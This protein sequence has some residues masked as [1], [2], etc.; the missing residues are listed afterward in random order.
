[1]RTRCK[2]YA[3]YGLTDARVKEIMQYCRTST[4]SKII[5]QAAEKANPSLAVYL[6]ESLKDRM[7]YDKLYKK[8]FIPLGCADFYAYRRLTIS[9]LDNVVP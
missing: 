1:M 5:E 9:L 7:S 3:D 4:D 8:Y 2:K 6:V